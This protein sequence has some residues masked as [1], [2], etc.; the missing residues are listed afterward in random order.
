M[1]IIDVI[2]MA[3]PTGTVPRSDNDASE[4]EINEHSVP[5]IPTD[6]FG[7]C[8]ILLER[9]GV[10]HS[11]M[12]GCKTLEDSPYAWYISDVE[13]LG[14]REAGKN[15]NKL[16]PYTSTGK[17]RSDRKKRKTVSGFETAVPPKVREWWD[18]LMKA[19]GE[20]LFFYRGPDGDLD[21]PEWWK[22]IFLMLI[23]ADEACAGIGLYSNAANA[24]SAVTWVDDIL[25]VSEREDLKNSMSNA[26]DKYGIQHRPLTDNAAF[27]LNPDIASVHPKTR[28]PK[29]GC[30]LRTLT[31]N[32]SLM[33]P[34]GQ[35]GSYWVRSLSTHYGK[36]ETDFNI[37]MI[38][39]PYM[40][41]P[42]WFESSDLGSGDHLNERGK[43]WNWFDIK[44]E[45]LPKTNSEQKKFIEFV[46]ELIKEAAKTRAIHCIAF[47]E[48]ALNWKIF[49]QLARKIRDEFL[50][51]EVLISGSSDNCKG[52]QG[53]YVMNALFY[54]GD[55][56][57]GDEKVRTYMVTSRAKHHRWRIDREQ[58]ETYGLET[59]LDPDLIWWEHIPIAPRE[60][61]HVVF[62]E[63]S[64]FT[65]LICEDLARSDPC[66]RNLRA[67]GPNLLFVLLMDGPQL[68][69]RWSARYST[70]LT[71]DPGTSVLTLTSRGLI[72]SS[73]DIRAAA[74]ETL[75]W[76][77]GLFKDDVSASVSISCPPN[78]QAS[79]M[80]LNV[81]RVDE[82]T[83][84]GR[85]KKNALTWRQRPKSQEQVKLGTEHQH[86]VDKFTLL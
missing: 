28:T 54:D 76:S 70:G 7:I 3:F 48:Y 17:P 67:V 75:D 43:T 11:L 1:R 9:S 81:E 85:K 86:L 59:A 50:T 49:E 32:L 12:P 66:H 55:K 20:P 56:S 47:P 27:Q 13:M 69:N 6:L 22:A 61:H 41:D 51:I 35:I 72:Q 19:S 4:R 26:T 45:W 21:P 68:S 10:Y 83:F 38:P 42:D 78:F 58:I 44:Q 30:T 63:G 60:L 80:S 31:H 40:L 53:N 39:F 29:V 33:P 14:A 5:P 79:V 16:T 36:P 24:P 37:L 23:T 84:D 62:R 71:D 73:N 52:D 57:E 82:T 18:A 77:I 34:R 64:I 65:A 8:A 25:K 15:W 46:C 2:N 74:G